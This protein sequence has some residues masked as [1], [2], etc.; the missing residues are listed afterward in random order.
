MDFGKRAQ[1]DDIA[2]C[3]NELQSI[4]R[5]V[6][7]FEVGLVEDD[8]NVLRNASHEIVNLILPNERAGRIIWIGNEGHPRLRSDRSQDRFEVETVVA[9]RDGHSLGGKKGSDQ[10]VGDKSVL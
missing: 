5:I 7:V 6:Q 8:H 10:P 3:P 1:D 9:V 2:V 4:G